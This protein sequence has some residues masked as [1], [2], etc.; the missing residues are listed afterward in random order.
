MPVHEH[1][2]AFVVELVPAWRA[3]RTTNPAL[4]ARALPVRPGR[5]LWLERCATARTGW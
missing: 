1:L 3:T 4:L 2:R 5:R